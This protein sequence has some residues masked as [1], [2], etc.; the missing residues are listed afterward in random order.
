[1][2]HQL[3]ARHGD[4]VIEKVATITGEL[5]ETKELVF[6]GDSSGHRHKVR[7]EGIS[8]RREGRNTLVRLAKPTKLSHDKPDGHKTIPLAAGCYS[9]RPLRERGDGTDRSVE[10]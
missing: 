8:F 9:V 7:G 4:L 6:A 3:Y 5:A 10:D 1:M 2:A